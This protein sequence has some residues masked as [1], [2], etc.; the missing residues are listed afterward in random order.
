MGQEYALQWQVF[1]IAEQSVCVWQHHWI[2]DR[3]SETDGHDPC[4]STW[5]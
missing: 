1:A 4:S 3:A 2:E 5:K